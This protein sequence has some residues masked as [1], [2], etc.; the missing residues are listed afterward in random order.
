MKNILLLIHDDAGQEARL[1][2]ALDITRALGGHLKCVDV[3][4][5]TVIP[6]D[7]FGSD[8]SA[9]LLEHEHPHDP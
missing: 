8:G 7:A 4:P 3:T 9:V 2:A 5:L 1:Q 6:D